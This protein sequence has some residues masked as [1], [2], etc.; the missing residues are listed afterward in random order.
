MTRASIMLGF[1]SGGSLTLGASRGLWVDSLG[2]EHDVTVYPS[3]CS[4]GNFNQLWCMALNVCSGPQPKHT[5]FAML[6]GDITP[7]AGWLAT[8]LAEMERVG[9]DLISAA[10]AIKDLRGMTSAGIGGNAVEPWQPT[11]RFTVK[12]LAK[13]PQ[14]FRAADFG[15]PD[16]P[17]WHNNGCWLAD[18]RKPVWYQADADGNAPVFFEY[19]ERVRR[20]GAGWVYEWISEDWQFSRRMHA[21]GVNSWITQIPLRHKGSLDYINVGDWGQEHDDDALRE[22]SKT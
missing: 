22:S 4:A 20:Q 12:E 21:A 2:P 10:P 8:L 19:L 9:A 13:L 18:L 17:L 3:E 14:T 1:P 15:Y 6:H 16:K 7:P 11:R 5:H